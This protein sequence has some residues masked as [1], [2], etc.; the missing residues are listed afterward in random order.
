MTTPVIQVRRGELAQ[1]AKAGAEALQH[2]QL[3]GFPTETVYG[4]ACMAGHTAAMERLRELKDRPHRPFSLHMAGPDEIHRY[5]RSIPPAARRLIA[6]AWPGP[7]TLLLSVGGSLP[8][9]TLQRQGL[10]DIL[11]LDDVIGLRCP[12]E[13]LATAMLDQAGASVVAPSANLTGEPSPR[14]AQEVL[15]GLDGRIDLLLDHGPTRYGQDSTIVSFVAEDGRSAEGCTIVREGVWSASAIRRMMKRR[16]VFVCTGNTCRSPMASGLAKKL[17]AAR[18][19]CSVGELRS[20]G[21]EVIS[22][23]LFASTGA[24]ATPEAVS[25][26]HQL[27][28]DISRHRSRPATA[29]LI[30]DAD[31]VFCMTQAHVSEARRLAGQDGQH[32]RLL[33]SSGDIPDPVGAGPD[34]YVRTA[35]RIEQ[36]LTDQMNKGTI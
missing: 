5:V 27:G 33:D 28:A 32:V 15:S 10:Y 19:G 9:E 12:D 2:G 35:R 13:P 16:I 22:A 11:S 34:V 4:I 8:D 14:S 36:A 21:I 29:E 20:A 1:A 24:H 7:V 30:R 31:M 18:E 23:G 3:V 6:K 17:L 26:A 25:A